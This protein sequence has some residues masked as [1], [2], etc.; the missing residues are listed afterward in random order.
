MTDKPAHISG[1]DNLTHSMG[2]L[3]QLH[4]ATV[5]LGQ[6]CVAFHPKLVLVTGRVT[7][8]LMLS[9]A[10]YWTRKLAIAESARQGWFWKTREEWRNETGLSRREQDSARQAL[11]DLGLWLEKRVGMPAKVWYRIDLDTLGW[12]LEPTGYTAWD[13]RNDRAVLQLLGRPFLFYRSLSDITGA[14]TSAV[15]LSNFLGQERARL[16][17]ADALTGWRPYLFNAL[18]QQTG[19]TRHELDSAR[20]GLRQTEVLAERRLGMPPRVEWQIRLDRLIAL[21][22]AVD[23]RPAS[24]NM[25]LRQPDQL[26][27]IGVVE[28]FSGNGPTSLRESDNPASRNPANLNAGIPRTGFPETYPLNFRDRTDWISGNA[29]TSWADSG[30]PDGRLPENLYVF[31][32]TGFK[33]TTP[34]EVTRTEDARTE[35]GGILVQPDGSRWFEQLIWPRTLRPEER[36]SA[37]RLLTPV[38]A[39]AQLLLDEL[40]GQT[41]SHK[42]IE[43]PLNYLSA[44]VSKARTGDFIPAAALREQARRQRIETERQAIAPASPIHPDE[45]ARHIQAGLNGLRTFMTQ[46]LGQSRPG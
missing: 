29:P 33:T 12:L 37:Q 3:N 34:T 32:T 43:Q 11:K 40:A 10:I 7:A 31:R 20:S 14:A 42:T 45:R 24:A 1:T 6:R 15:L 4:K 23:S 8:G 16:K 17:N 5:L 36:E 46:R 38:S 13:W 27:G 21:L 39:Q 35:A 18:R 26:A 30:T 41:L 2:R 28:R 44:L 25:E 9:Q 19:L 22:A